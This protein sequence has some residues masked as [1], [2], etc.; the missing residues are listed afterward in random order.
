M[1]TAISAQEERCTVDGVTLQVFRAGLGPTLLVLHDCEVM[2]EWQPYHSA[3]AAH[4]TVLAPSHPGFG[5]SERAEAI[6][7]IDDLA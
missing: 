3:L 4:F 6:D 1:V 2:T 7:S 5:D